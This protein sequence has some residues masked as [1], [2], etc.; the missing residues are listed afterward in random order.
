MVDFAQSS[1]LKE[2]M[3]WFFF[4]LFNSEKVAQKFKLAKYKQAWI[5]NDIIMVFTDKNVSFSIKP[6]KT[7]V[8]S[9]FFMTV[10]LQ[11]WQMI[12]VKQQIT[13]AW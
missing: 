8:L 9:V 7:A 12:V 4:L 6:G 1:V 2:I 11:R 5:Q 3:F 13:V 10:A